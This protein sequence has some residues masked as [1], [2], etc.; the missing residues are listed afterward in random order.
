V[1]EPDSGRGRCCGD[2]KRRKVR[3]NDRARR[4][5]GNRDR[6]NSH[7]LAHHEPGSSDSFNFKIFTA[8][9]KPGQVGAADCRLNSW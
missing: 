1:S 3:A 2:S 6:P 5:R 8:H 7:N 4:K 9:R